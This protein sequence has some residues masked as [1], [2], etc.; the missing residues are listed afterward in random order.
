MSILSKLLRRSDEYLIEQVKRGNNQAYLEIFERYQKGVYNFSLGYCRRSEIATEITQEC[1]LKLFSKASSFDGNKAFR[2]WFW[3][4]VRNQ[5]HD[6]YRKEKG[7][8][9]LLE[10]SLAS[11]QSEGVLEDAPFL[12]L[13]QKIQQK[14]IWDIVQSLLPAERDALMLWLEELD[15]KEMA[16]VLNK[17]PDAVKGLLKRAKQRFAKL[18]QEG[19]EQ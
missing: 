16:L 6:W 5:C 7:S 15:Y 2:P 14:R 8:S 3:S 4:L 13:I 11:E 1:F 19:E 9:L 12:L 18:W 17:S 10:D